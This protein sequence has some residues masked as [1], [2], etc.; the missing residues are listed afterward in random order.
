MIS[1][2]KFRWVIVDDY[3]ITSTKIT[4]PSEHMP[5]HN[6]SAA[7]LVRGSNANSCRIGTMILSTSSRQITFYTVNQYN[8]TG[9]GM[10]GCA[11]GERVNG[12]LM[13]VIN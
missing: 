9:Y 10:S 1:C 2:Y 6:V 13:W 5:D 11:V 8:S 4:I 12:Q 3:S 7:I